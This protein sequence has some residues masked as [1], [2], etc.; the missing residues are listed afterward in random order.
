MS[1]GIYVNQSPAEAKFQRLFKRGGV[2]KNRYC[3]YTNDNNKEG[4]RGD[5]KTGDEAEQ[6][7]KRGDANFNFNAIKTKGEERRKP[8]PFEDQ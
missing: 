5:Y 1:P 2:N 8:K 4:K 6:A 7:E 3:C